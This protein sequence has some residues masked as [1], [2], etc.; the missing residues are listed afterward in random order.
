M[1]RKDGLQRKPEMLGDPE[2]EIETWVVVPA[3]EVADGLDVDPQS[4]CKV[5]SGES[6]LGPKDRNPVLNRGS[7]ATYCCISTTIV[8]LR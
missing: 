5:L 6:P 3:F 4:V 7:H 2:R 1:A 8:G